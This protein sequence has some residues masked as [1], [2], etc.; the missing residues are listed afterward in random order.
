MCIVN[1]YF[2]PFTW[3][4]VKKIAQLIQPVS[5]HK[6]TLFLMPMTRQG[7]EVLDIGFTLFYLQL[8]VTL[9]PTVQL[10][11]MF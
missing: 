7:V 5:K 10:S 4:R 2:S 11:A 8:E 1:K 9:F 6:Q 3:Y